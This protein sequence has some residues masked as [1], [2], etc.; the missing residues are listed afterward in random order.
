[1]SLKH[2][3]KKLGDLAGDW[4]RAILVMINYSGCRGML[5]RINFKAISDPMNNLE[6]T[7][8]CIKSG[9]QCRPYVFTFESV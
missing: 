9:V 4:Q 5:L 6:K 8:V 1:M 3:G 7:K 2:G